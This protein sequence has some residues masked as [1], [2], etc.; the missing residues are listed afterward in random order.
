MEHEEFE[1]TEADEVRVVQ[2]ALKLRDMEEA[3][4]EERDET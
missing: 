1:V 3:E 4:V 2:R